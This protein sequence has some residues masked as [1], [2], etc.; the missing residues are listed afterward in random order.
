M[1]DMRAYKIICSN[2][3][4]PPDMGRLFPT[5]A[6]LQAPADGDDYEELVDDDLAC[7]AIAAEMGKYR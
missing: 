4:K 3:T 2:C 6:G 1:D 5:L 7:Q